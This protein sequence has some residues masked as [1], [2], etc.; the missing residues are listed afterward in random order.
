MRSGGRN[1]SNSHELALIDKKKIF[2]ELDV[3]H[4]KKVGIKRFSAKEAEMSLMAMSSLESARGKFFMN[5]T[6]IM[7]RKKE[8]NVFGLRR[9]K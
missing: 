6:H 1:E 9:P 8:S 5:S 4:V 7:S 2:H 3:H